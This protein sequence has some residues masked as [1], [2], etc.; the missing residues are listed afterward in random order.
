M[1]DKC[2]YCDFIPAMTILK[3]PK[4]AG[5]KK[6]RKP[7]AQKARTRARSGDTRMYVTSFLKT[8][9]PDSRRNGGV[10]V[11]GSTPVLAAKEGTDVDLAV[12]QLLVSNVQPDTST[13]VG[14]KAALVAQA[15][16]AIRDLH[17]FTQIRADIP[18]GPGRFK[19]LTDIVLYREPATPNLPAM[20]VIDIKSTLSTKQE[21]STIY[22]KHKM[23]DVAG[24]YG[25]TKKDMDLLQVAIYA[26]S[27]QADAKHPTAPLGYIVRV[28]GRGDALACETHPMEES[29][30]LA[31][32]KVNTPT[33][34]DV[35]SIEGVR[36]S[37][38]FCSCASG[39]E[40]APF[41]K[42]ATPKGALC[43]REYP[44]GSTR[45]V[46]WIRLIPHP[47]VVPDAENMIRI[48]AR[49]TLIV[50]NE[51]HVCTPRV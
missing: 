51:I 49:G 19:G 35:P 28:Y 11:Q 17:G 47:D 18:C 12:K 36:M 15:I 20:C 29:H 38:E 48:V 24:G 14:K 50:D 13:V 27:L 3:K 26:A 2:I 4:S 37:A 9:Y 43:V 21:G 25:R 45:H 33:T 5:V 40:W 41:F 8:I 23:K 31:G 44:D 22:Q 10:H 42:G 16:L 6:A 7:I 32:I 39:K 46:L 1:L 30:L 34:F